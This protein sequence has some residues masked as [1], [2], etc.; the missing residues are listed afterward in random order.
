VK[1]VAAAVALVVVA[2]AGC[3]GGSGGPTD[4]QQIETVVLTYY[5]AFGKGDS[6]RACTELS[7]VTV[8][9]LEKAGRGKDC[10]EILDAALKRPDYA[11]I[12]QKLQATRVTLV[13]VVKDKAVARV[14]VPGVKA[15][16]ALGVRTT[17][18]L[19]KEHGA[20]KIFGA[21]Q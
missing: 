9:N 8:A 14:L 15:N 1:G 7:S 21:P 18:P 10:A 2:I 13:R 3:G 19:V 20:W 5:K 12:A 17:V 16:G 11:E 4:K 6:A